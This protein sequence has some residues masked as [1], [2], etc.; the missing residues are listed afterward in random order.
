MKKVSKPLNGSTNQPVEKKYIHISE[1]WK[2]LE[3]KVRFCTS[4]ALKVKED[5]TEF[6]NE[7]GYSA[8]EIEDDRSLPLDPQF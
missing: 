3:L 8:M 6:W 2:Q 4:T 1:M 7:R 5:C